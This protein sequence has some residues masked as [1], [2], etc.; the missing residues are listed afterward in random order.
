MF[1]DNPAFNYVIVHTDHDYQ[2]D[3]AQDTHWAHDHQEFDVYV[4]GTIG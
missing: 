3:G 1:N 4:G 2:W